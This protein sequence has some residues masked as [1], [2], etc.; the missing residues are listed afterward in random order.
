MD[1]KITVRTLCTSDFTN[2]IE[3]CK[4]VYPGAH[5]WNELQLGSHLKVF[6]EGQFI[7]VDQR[8]S[9]LV[10]Y[11]ASLIIFWDDYDMRM[12]W[13]D[14]TDGG[15]FTNHD[16]VRGRTLY[17]AEVMV[18][19]DEQGKGVGTLLYGARQNLVEKRGILRIRAGARLRGFHRYA[20]KMKPEDYLLEVVK[21]QIHDPT[22]TFQIRRGFHVLDLVSHYL[23]H[24]PESLGY[25]AIIEWLNSR[26]ATDED[27]RWQRSSRF[28]SASQNT[29]PRVVLSGDRSRKG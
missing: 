21:Q 6:P 14:F 22:L 10:G 17:G 13:R 4:R 16:P 18:R 8:T 19:P 23:G 9:E 29:Q 2:V 5:P 27:Y 1:G 26:L 7:A 12:S 20:S 28:F 3:L 15:M 24:D 11:A 25:A